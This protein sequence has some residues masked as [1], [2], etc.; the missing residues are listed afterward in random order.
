ME[1]YEVVQ[2]LKHWCYY[3]IHI[4]L[5]YQIRIWPGAE[6]KTVLK[7]REGLYE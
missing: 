5:A 2:A 7:T 6:W 1:Y 4:N 3:L